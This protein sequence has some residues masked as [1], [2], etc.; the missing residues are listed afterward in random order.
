M[1]K[2]LSIILTFA[3]VL[4]AFAG[5]TQ[6]ETTVSSESDGFKIV[7]TPSDDNEN[8][9]DLHTAKQEAYLDGD[10]NEISKYCKGE[11][12]F[13]KTNVISYTYSEDF[14]LT[15]SENDDMSESFT[16]SSENKTAYVDNLKVGTTY[17]VTASVGEKT[18][19]LDNIVTDDCCPRIINVD[20]VKNVRDVGGWNTLDGGKVKQGLLFRCGRMNES[21]TSEVNIEVTKSGIE[22]MVGYLG[23]KTDIDLRG[24]GEKEIGG[25]TSSPLGESVAYRNTAMPYDPDIFV[26]NEEQLLEVFHILS[27]ESNYPIAFH[28]NIGTDRTGMIAFLVN[29]LLGVCEE[30]L[31]KDYC[32]SNFA[33]IGGSRSIDGLKNHEYYKAVMNTEGDTLSEKI[34]NFLLNLGVTEDEIQSVISILKVTK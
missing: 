4:T 12:S 29:G 33:D 2:A 25:I 23:I 26:G 22:T 9:V 7:Y 15:L 19:K 31:Y 1:K 5:C 30:D 28:C 34:H 14:T 10:P 18:V 11:K 6:K 16:V 13:D 21:N 20:G 3:I 32:F 17:Y 8:K 24:N 27:D